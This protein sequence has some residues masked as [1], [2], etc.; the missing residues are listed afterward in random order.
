MQNRNTALMIGQA[1]ALTTLVSA[2]ILGGCTDRKLVP[3]EQDLPENVDDLV[4]IEAE[5]CTRPVEDVVF[6]VKLLLV[7]DT[8]GSLQFT[9]QSGLRR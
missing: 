7:L 5:F 1:L 2:P 4:D 9:D 8:S 6:P 3:V